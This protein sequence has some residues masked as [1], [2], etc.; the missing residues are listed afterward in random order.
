MLTSVSFAA[1]FLGGY[2]QYRA[3]NSSLSLPRRTPYRRTNGIIS[4][5][6]WGDISV[7]FGTSLSPGLARREKN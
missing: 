2:V 7:D 5:M 6:P 1:A 3:T 4:K